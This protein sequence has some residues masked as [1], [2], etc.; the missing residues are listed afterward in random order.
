MRIAEI[1]DSLVYH[2][3]NR[4]FDVFEPYNGA[5]G[6][7]VYFTQHRTIAQ[8][9]ARRRVQEQGGV[10]RVI[11]VRLGGKIVWNG[12]SEHADVTER[13]ARLVRQADARG[14]SLLFNDALREMV[15]SAGYIGIGAPENFVVYDPR[16]I[17]SHISESEVLAHTE[18]DDAYYAQMLQSLWARRSSQKWQS[19]WPFQTLTTLGDVAVIADHWPMSLRQIVFFVLRPK[20]EVLPIG[21][22]SLHKGGRDGDPNDDFYSVTMIWVVP[23]WRSRGIARAFYDFMQQHVNMVPDKMQSAG[24]EGIWRSRRSQTISETVIPVGNRQ[25]DVVPAPI[26]RKYPMVMINVPAFDRGFARDRGFY[27]GPGGSGDAIAGR[28][29]RFLEFLEKNDS[30]EASAVSVGED[31]KV[32]F[33]NGRHRYAVLRD[34]G[35]TVMPVVVLDGLE[36]AERFGYLHT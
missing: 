27:I 1:V 6:H 20:S 23:E 35:V 8:D 24:G 18:V 15:T 34:L 29:Q 14:R 9:Y 19:A 36:N 7:G 26:D 30:M 31:G 25:I 16:N 11:P 22:A 21:F 32:A 3:T 17:M 2:G 28:Y 33:S 5:L 13:A 10:A 12:T 4:D